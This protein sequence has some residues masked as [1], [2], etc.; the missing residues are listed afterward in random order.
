MIALERAIAAPEADDPAAWV[1]R[2]HTELDAFRGVWQ[3]HVEATERP[4]GLLDRVLHEVPRLAHEHELLRREHR[5]VAAA[6]DALASENDAD[7]AREGV[8]ALL[9]RLV[10]HR[11]RGANFVYDAYSVDVGTSE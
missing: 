7:A 4:G 5:E 8:I 11:S 3:H 6:I 2:V 9:G 1:G 10:R